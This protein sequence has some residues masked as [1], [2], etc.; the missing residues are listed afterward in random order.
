[1][2]TLDIYIYRNKTLLTL[3]FSVYITSRCVKT[4]VHSW[5]CHT[6]GGMTNFYRTSS[7]CTF[8]VPMRI[9]V[10]KYFKETRS[11]WSFRGITEAGRRGLQC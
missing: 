3:P 2:Y 5:P 1:M 8:N 11:C 4:N 7:V 10:D 9:K 6:S